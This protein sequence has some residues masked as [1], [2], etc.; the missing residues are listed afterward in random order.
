MR[1]LKSDDQDRFASL[2]KLFQ[3]IAS[4][5]HQDGQLKEPDDAVQYSDLLATTDTVV[6]KPAPVVKPAVEAD[7]ISEDQ[8]FENRLLYMSIMLSILI[9]VLPLLLGILVARI[10]PR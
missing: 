8:K 5:F 1:H 3:A 2:N 6:V 9:D 10:R 4:L 7:P